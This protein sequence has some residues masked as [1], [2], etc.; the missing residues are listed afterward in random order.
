VPRKVWKKRYGQINDFEH[1]LRHNGTRIVK[2]FL[3]ISRDEQ[4]RRLEERIR[5]PH[6]RWKFDPSD[7]ETRKHWKDY[8]RAFE[9]M[10]TRCSTPYAPWY[11]IPADNKWFRNVAVSQILVQELEDLPLRFPKPA[12]DPAKIQVR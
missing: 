12:Y 4:K 10:L 9:A 11:V 7:L 3:H 1:M 2:L 6:K 5:E 8:Q